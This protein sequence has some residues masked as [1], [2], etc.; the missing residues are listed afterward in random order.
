M[1]FK[2]SIEF[3]LNSWILVVGKHFLT[4]DFKLFMCFLTSLSTLLCSSNSIKLPANRIFF[5]TLFSIS[6]ISRRKTIELFW[7][8]FAFMTPL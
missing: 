2:T 8:S 6:S 7:A 1:K 3:T 5:S 4:L